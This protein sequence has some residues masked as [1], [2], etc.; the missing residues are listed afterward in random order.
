MA[1]PKN[2][3]NVPSSGTGSLDDVS[4]SNFGGFSLEIDDLSITKGELVC[5]IG[6]VGS[7]KSSL[8]NAMLGE[9]VLT[10]RSDTT[11]FDACGPRS[12]V[13]QTACK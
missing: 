6:V 2:N 9:L 11:T 13:S 8:L 7:G 1:D 3:I 5:V 4:S 10:E 12:Y